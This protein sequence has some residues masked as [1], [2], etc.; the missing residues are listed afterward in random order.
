M[1]DKDFDYGGYENIEPSE[2]FLIGLDAVTAAAAFTG[3]ED[4]LTSL[5][6]VSLDDDIAFC[7]AFKGDIKIG[8]GETLTGIEGQI[9]FDSPSVTMRA[10]QSCLEMLLPSDS[11]QRIAAVFQ[12]EVVKMVM[13]Q[14]SPHVMESFVQAKMASVMEGEELNAPEEDH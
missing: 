10:I 7:L 12:E 14:R 8:L 1:T 3:R 6:Q 5:D 11:V 4:K 2:M 9:F 13:E